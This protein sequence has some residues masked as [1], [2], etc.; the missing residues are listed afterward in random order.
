M[1]AWDVRLNEVSISDFKSVT[2][3]KVTLHEDEEKKSSS[4]LGIY[5]QNGSGKTALVDSIHILKYLL[6]GYRIPDY[7]AGYIAEGSDRASFEFDIRIKNDELDYRVW[8]RFSL[9]KR[10]NDDN[11]D[12]SKRIIPVVEKECISFSRISG[13]EKLRKTTLADTD[14]D[15]VFIPIS[16][17]NALVG[18]YSQ[19]ELLV[20]KK[21]AKR[22]S[23]S[24]LFSPEFLSVIKK[25]GEDEVAKGILTR[26]MHYGRGELFVVDTQNLGMIQLGAL[27]VYFRM[28]EGN[29]RS[30]GVFPIFLGE[31]NPVPYDIYDKLHQSI[32]NIN[33]V[34]NRVI[35]GMS[36]KTED[37]GKRLME[38]GEE[39]YMIGLK[40]VRNG[41]EIPLRYESDGIKKILS[42]LQLLIV[43]YNRY[44]FTVVIDELDSG[45]FEYLLGEMLDLLSKKGKGQLVFTSHNLRPLETIDKKFVVFTT[46][47]P[48]NRFVR[49]KNVKT[50]NNLRDFY[51][52]ELEL[53]G[54]SEKLYEDT[55]KYE[56]EL[57]L[58][59]AG[60]MLG[61]KE[62]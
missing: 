58:R 51:Y 2:K 32:D 62:G 4:V 33:V 49:M 54:Q 52:R 53:G 18:E 6:S 28:S 10:E 11:D 7:F 23:R 31:E 57:A 25:N 8:Y 15:E 50:N 46:T 48:S 36:V 42:I 5:G 20:E 61:A 21:L 35:P 45:I 29:K 39:G 13:I 27:P 60:D 34:L 22:E 3:G 55:N 38:N 19:V 9:G 44:S 24:F 14:T 40:S 37:L 1:G 30:A 26:L 47:N 41:K 17:Y 59:K 16:R 12:G 43:M 56:I